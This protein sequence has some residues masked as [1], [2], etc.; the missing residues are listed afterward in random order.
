[1][2]HRDLKAANLYFDGGL[3]K[4]A[5]FETVLDDNSENTCGTPGIMAPEQYS[6][7]VVDWKADQYAAGGSQPSYDK[8]FVRDWL[9]TTD[10]DKNSTP[11]ALPDEIVAKTREKYIGAYEQLTGKTFP[12][13]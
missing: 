4:L 10:W 7:T 6:S 5:D 12:W 3:L 11:P 2:V 13:K 1:M 9:S 8:Q